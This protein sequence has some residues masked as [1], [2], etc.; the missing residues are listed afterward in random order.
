MIN[1]TVFSGCSDK[2]YDNFTIEFKKTYFEI[3]ETI[4]ASST[5]EDISNLQNASNVQGI[6]KLGL[7]LESI[8][9]NVPENKADE[10]KRFVKWYNGLILL[11]DL[12]N[13]AD[14]LTEDKKIEIGTELIRVSLRKDDY[15]EK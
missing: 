7:L 1:I 9:N 14:K 12:S 3:V 11:N 6:E 15:N 10:Y 2:E 5:S 13:K 4:D 8:K